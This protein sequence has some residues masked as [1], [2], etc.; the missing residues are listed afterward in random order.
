V[1]GFAVVHCLGILTSM[2]S[3]VFVSRGVVNLWYGR[4]KK[5]TTLSIGTVWVPGTSK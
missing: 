2:F 5:L 1:R 4:K 3:A